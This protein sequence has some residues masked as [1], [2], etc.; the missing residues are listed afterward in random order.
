MTEKRKSYRDNTANNLAGRDPILVPV[1]QASAIIARSPRMVYEMMA[2]GELRAVKSGRNT[3][4]LY[5]SIKEYV[6]KLRPA[7]IKP[8]IRPEG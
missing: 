7:K 6:A 4:I 3:L 5:D 1:N 2:A 8:Y